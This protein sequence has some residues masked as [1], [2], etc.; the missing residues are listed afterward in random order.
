LV[1]LSRQAL[2][3]IKELHEGKIKAALA[4]AQDLS[5]RYRLMFIDGNIAPETYEEV[6]R[7]LQLYIQS[8]Q[9]SVE[10]A[11]RQTL[12]ETV[13]LLDD[14]EALLNMPRSVATDRLKELEDRYAKMLVSGAIDLMAYLQF[15]QWALAVLQAK[16][17][18]ADPVLAGE[19]AGAIEA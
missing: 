18:E 12:Q 8:C 3:E 13:N 9:S 1:K 17:A 7:P 14:S 16:N 11:D 2:A 10:Q 4:A 5:E 6:D 15:R 19:S